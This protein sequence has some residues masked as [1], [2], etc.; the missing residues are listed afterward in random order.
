[1]EECFGRGASGQFVFGGAQ[2][3]RN[4]AMSAAFAWPFWPGGRMFQK[5]PPSFV[6]KGWTGVSEG[7]GG[8]PGSWGSPGS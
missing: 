5:P 3:A 6:P 1:L 2:A 4:A 7:S 8:P